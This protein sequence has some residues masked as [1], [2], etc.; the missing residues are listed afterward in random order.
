MHKRKKKSN[1]KLNFSLK[2]CFVYVCNQSWFSHIKLTSNLPFYLR[3]A[4]ELI[5]WRFFFSF[6]SCHQKCFLFFFNLVDIGKRKQNSKKRRQD[7]LY[8]FKNTLHW[9]CVLKETTP[10]GLTSGDFL[11]RTFSVRRYWQHLSTSLKI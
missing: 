6:F 8:I 4:P 1:Y 3:A 11:Q 5:F 9:S 10:S 2:K 7:F